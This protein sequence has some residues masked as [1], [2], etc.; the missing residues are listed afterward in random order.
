MS[1][2]VLIVYGTRYGSTEEIA[3][4]FKETLEEKGFIVDL[5]NLKAKKRDKMNI[6][7]YSGLLV[8]SGIRIYR[9]T[10]E[11]KNFLKKNVEVINSNKKP[12]GIFLSSGEASDPD[13]R[14]AAIEKYLLEVFKELGL[15]LG[16]NVLYDAFGGVFDMSET[17]NL[18]W[19]MKK[20]MSMGADEDPNIIRNERNDLRDWDQ[21]NQFIEEFIRKL[22]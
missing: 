12:L 10:K 21:I 7:D 13:K 2:K 18:S 11:A 9:W 5:V 20:F 22:E 8:G 6:N 17:S 14:P 19:I 3:T 16:E 4:K 15:I 1:K